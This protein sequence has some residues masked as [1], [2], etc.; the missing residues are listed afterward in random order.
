MANSGNRNINPSNSNNSNNNQQ[1]GVSFLLTGH[2]NLHT[3]AT[4]AAQFVGYI[5]RTLDN[6]II[7]DEGRVT[8][9]FIKSNR[10]NRPRNVREWRE[11]RSQSASNQSDRD[12]SSSEPGRDESQSQ[13]QSNQSDQNDQQSGTLEQLQD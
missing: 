5:N 2:I 3:S 1:A 8:A 6:L 12:E 13:N 11:R 10:G 7:D 4:C 9:R